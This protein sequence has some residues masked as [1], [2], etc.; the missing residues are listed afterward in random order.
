MLQSILIFIEGKLALPALVKT[1]NSRLIV[2][3]SGGMLNTKFPS[4]EVA[5]CLGETPFDGQLAY[6]YAKRGQVLL[7]EKWAQQYAG[8]PV[9]VSCHPGGL[10][11]S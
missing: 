10:K 4:W 5:T 9:V 6:A 7:C 11:F 3:S 1:P 2:V 8:V